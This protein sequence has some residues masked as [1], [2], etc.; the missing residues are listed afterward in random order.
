MSEFGPKFTIA[1]IVTAVIVLAGI[2]YL[3]SGGEE[4]NEEKK[5]RAGSPPFG[6][7][8]K[9]PNGNDS[10]QPKFQPPHPPPA[11][12]DWYV[13]ERFGVGIAAP[14]G[15]LSR[16]E[17]DSFTITEQPLDDE[18][19]REVENTGVTVTF[20]EKRPKEFVTNFLKAFLPGMEKAGKIVITRWQKRQINE[21]FCTYNCMYVDMDLYG[22]QPDTE[23]EA[24][25]S[26]MTF[27][28]LIVNEKT[29]SFW[30]CQFESPKQTFTE[31]FPSIGQTM[32]NNMFFNP[33]V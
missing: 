19:G 32:V 1:A 11:N 5:R 16:E 12:F 2:G 33:Y 27:V 13:N 28:A 20:M 15:W 29:G 26:I 10:S 25:P 22:S 6:G 30:L 8:K 21:T 17:T 18:A 31:V 23:E 3:A 24:K 14:V 4:E 9:Y 7:P